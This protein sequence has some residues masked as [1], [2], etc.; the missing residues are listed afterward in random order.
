MYELKWRTRA[1]PTKKKKKI[2]KKKEWLVEDSPPFMKKQ[3]GKGATNPAAVKRNLN[4]KDKNY[5]FIPHYRPLN[6]TKI[7]S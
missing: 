3:T 5:A 6:H 1:Y 4:E 7:K 2:Q